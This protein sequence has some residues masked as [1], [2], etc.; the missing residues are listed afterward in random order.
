M[1]CEFRRNRGR[2]STSF[3]VDHWA[4]AVNMNLNLRYDRLRG[5]HNV[6]AISTVERL[7]R[8]KTLLEKQ[9]MIYRDALNDDN[10]Y[11]KSVA[12]F[13]KGQPKA[14]EIYWQNLLAEYSGPN[15]STVEPIN[16]TAPCPNGPP[17]CVSAVLGTLAVWIPN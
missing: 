7:R 5:V 16:S 11:Q 13:L 2:S 14:W 4:I 10:M 1:P 12:A 8:G 15:G 9:K 3:C 17:V 6:I